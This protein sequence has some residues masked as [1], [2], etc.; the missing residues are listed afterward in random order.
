MKPVSSLVV[1]FIMICFILQT[2]ITCLSSV[3]SVDFKP[4]ELEVAVVTTSS[5]KFRYVHIA[6]LLKSC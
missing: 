6:T 3:L 4:S 5:P 1:L 2:A